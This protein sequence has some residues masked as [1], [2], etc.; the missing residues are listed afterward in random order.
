MY[1]PTEGQILF[2]GKELGIDS[3]KRSMRQKGS[4]QIVF[5]DP[6]GS[7]NPRRSIL[8]SFELALKLHSDY[9]KGK[10]PGRVGELLEMV[11]LP[12]EY[13]HKQPR[14]LGGGERQLVSIARALAANPSLI[15]LDEPTSA[16]DVSMQAKVINKL[17]E[18]QENMNLSYL[19]I[20][21]DLSLMR[22]VASRVAIMYLGRL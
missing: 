21:H 9:P 7:F 8:Q 4:I 11:G 20:T 2:N 13:M 14:S 5:Q 17:M 6:G 15:I 22:N 12:S 1:R 19:F 18:L 10:W 3:K 16:L